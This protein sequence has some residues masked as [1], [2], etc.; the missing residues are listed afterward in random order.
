MLEGERNWR[1]YICIG[2]KRIVTPHRCDNP[3][4]RANNLEDSIWRE[5]E[6]RLSQPELIYEWLNT[7][8]E[9]SENREHIERQLDTLSKRMSALEKQRDRIHK[10][11]YITGDERQFKHDLEALEKDVRVLE[12]SKANIESRIN[13]CID[14]EDNKQQIID[15]CSLVRKNLK[16][17]SFDEKRLAL[18][19][20]KV[21]VWIDGD[22][23]TVEGAIPIESET[24]SPLSK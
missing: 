18:E 5:V 2:K 24:V 17:P 15:A 11:Y 23:V 6:K 21:K 12:E 10:A 3:N 16:T 8:S 13:A 9:E 22:N 14:F 7:M 4:Y 19:A 1:Y 20:L